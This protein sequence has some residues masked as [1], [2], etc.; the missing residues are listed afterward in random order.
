MTYVEQMNVYKKR[1][2]T[3]C[4]IK[5]GDYV[6]YSGM[7][8]EMS[9]INIY[10][11]CKVTEVIRGR[12]GDGQIRSFKVKMIKGGKIKELTRNIRRFSLLELHGTEQL[13]S[14]SEPSSTPQ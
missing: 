10:Q 1:N 9:P 12:D 2:Q 5:V 13:P 3:E 4:N 14:S 8:K 6:I 7:N 11:I